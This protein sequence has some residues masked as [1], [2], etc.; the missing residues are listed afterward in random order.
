MVRKYTGYTGVKKQSTQTDAAGQWISSTE[1]SRE[2]Y[3]NT[4]PGIPTQ[5]YTP[6]GAIAFA[7]T[8]GVVDT[9]LANDNPFLLCDGAAVS[10]STYAEL[11]AAIGTRFGAGNGSTTFN[12]PDLYDTFVY[13][14]GETASGV[15]PV[16]GSGYITEDH[17]HNFS[18]TTFS[19]TS[20]DTNPGGNDRQRGSSSNS[21]ISSSF[22]GEANNEMRKREFIP[23]LSTSNAAVVGKGTIH[24]FLLPEY[25]SSYIPEGYLICSG[26]AISREGN[27]EL[28]G[29]IS[30]HFGGGDGVNTFNIPDL[31]GM[32]IS[33]SRQPS[34]VRTPSG[35]FTNNFLPDKFFQHSH[36][37]PSENTS[38]QR[39]GGSNAPRINQ[40]SS[41]TAINP[42]S[43]SSTGNANESR[44]D[45][46][47]IVFCIAA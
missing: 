10:R 32:F 13:L 8:S 1:C 9:E 46:I 23:L 12:V 28:F 11:F 34:N 39:G 17:N 2:L 4:F 30:T 5:R 36:T 3:A 18:G 40:P 21:N 33:S 24:P 22:D 41:T 20:S 27:S 15:T 37:F 16:T 6:A 19:N 26:Q 43:A 25:D 31:R 35:E 44:A 29:L 47:S 45:N 7:S 42:A 38:T 14:K